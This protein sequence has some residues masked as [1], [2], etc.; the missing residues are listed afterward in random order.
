M[1]SGIPFAWAV[2]IVESVERRRDNRQI[3][4]RTEPSARISDRRA[5]LLVFINSGYPRVVVL[6]AMLR[7][8]WIVLP[9]RASF[10][11]SIA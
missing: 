7:Q 10:Q 2:E 9:F 6:A 11:V 8:R 1:R 3:G 5:E 4:S